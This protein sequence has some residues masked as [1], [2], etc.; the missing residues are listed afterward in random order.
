MSDLDTRLEQWRTQTEAL[1]TP[2]P[3]AAQLHA[4][5]LAQAALGPKPAA[6]SLAAKICLSL[7]L[8]GAVTLGVAAWVTRSTQP[9]EAPTV[10]VAPA[11]MVIAEVDAGLRAPT[12]A[13]VAVVETHLREEPPTIAEGRPSGSD[14]VPSVVVGRPTVGVGLQPDAMLVEATPGDFVACQ[15]TVLTPS[16]RRLQPELERQ[17]GESAR[18]LMRL[19]AEE[20]DYAL[21]LSLANSTVIAL[22]LRVPRG[23]D[24]ATVVTQREVG[25]SGWLVTTI[26]DPV[27]PVWLV[28]PG[29]EPVE[30][31]VPTAQPGE[32]YAGEIT[33]EA[34]K[35]SEAAR[36]EVVVTSPRGR[37]E[38]SLH[39]V[40][41]DNNTPSH[42]TYDPERRAWKSLRGNH[43]VFDGLAR[44]RWRLVV[45]EAGSATREVPVGVLEP[46]ANLRHVSLEAAR[47]VTV[48]YVKGPPGKL[49][50]VTAARLDVTPGE[51][52]ALGD[53]ALRIDQRE[54][55]L[56]FSREDVSGG[57][58]GTGTLQ[59]FCATDLRPTNR[60]SEHAIDD[61]EVF[62][63]T[64]A[65]GTFT[66]MR[67]SVR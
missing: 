56:R 4:L 15:G 27:L 1:Q 33:L 28:A 20:R 58:L 14:A 19:L 3:L 60:F 37:A 52:F 22:H 6:L 61:G 11:P 2:Q 36:L 41:C 65:D 47:R 8:L 10:D 24:P 44:A 54:G 42:G 32:W 67:F 40:P 21:R 23:V 30:V 49:C 29:F 66:L 5:A 39:P 57:A 18:E 46:G 31:H 13:P 63:T 43:V 45:R 64:E 53:V 62:V 55:Q 34:L 50:G 25:R 38:V 48:E 59:R 26:G 35:P 51:P 7:L 12:G 9:A 17:R 16:L